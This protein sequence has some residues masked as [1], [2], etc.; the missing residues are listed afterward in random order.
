MQNRSATELGIQQE[1]VN[2]WINYSREAEYTKL[3]V[4]FEYAHDHPQGKK[5]LR[6]TVSSIGACCGCTSQ[7][8]YVIEDITERKLAEE[9]LR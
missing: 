9:H 3:P 2:E 5:L 1:Y 4:S 7:F 6:S 8:A